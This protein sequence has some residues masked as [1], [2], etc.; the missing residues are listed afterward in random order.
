MQ[1]DCEKMLSDLP[2]KILCVP[3]HKTKLKLFQQNTIECQNDS[4]QID[5]KDQLSVSLIQFLYK[6]IIL[7]RKRFMFFSKTAS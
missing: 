2:K 1:D 4:K 5:Y 6:T 3:N 7:I